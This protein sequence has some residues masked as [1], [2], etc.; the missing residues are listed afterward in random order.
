[1][2]KPQRFRPIIFISH[3]ARQ[4]AKA[5]TTLKTVGAHLKSNG[6]DVLVDETRIQGGEPWRDCLHT[7]M[8]H[9]HGGV[10]LLTPKALSSAWVLKEATIL[11][12]RQSLSAGS[13]PLLPV[14]LGV[15]P[16]DL[17]KSEQFS[18]LALTEIQALKKLTEL[19]L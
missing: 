1:M 12:W 3:S 19:A 7:W 11:S 13:F 6:F 2:P 8:G 15:Q 5:Y 18:P 9:C 14:F 17:A 16:G 10:V 4:D